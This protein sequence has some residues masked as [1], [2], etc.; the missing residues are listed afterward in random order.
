MKAAA[1]TSAP[2]VADRIAQ[3]L[4][5]YGVTQMFSQSLP[6][7]LILA[8]EDANIRQV[9]YRTENAGGA[10]A[11]AFARLSNKVGIV[12]AQNGPAATL[13]VP[14]L[15]EALKASIPI[16]ALVQEVPRHQSDK[17]AFQELDHHSLFIPCT[18]WVRTVRN[19]DRVEDYVRQAFLAATTGRPGPAALLLPADLLSEQTTQDRAI[20][21][22]FA[23]GR[24]PLDRTVANSDA[25]ARAADIIAQAESPIV[26]AGGGVHSAQGAAALAKLQEQMSLPVATTMMGK[27]SVDEGHPLSIGLVGNVMGRGS[28]GAHTRSI[29]D[30]ADV[31]LL[32][33][34]RTNQNGTDSWQLFPEN[35]TIIHVDIDGQEVGRNFPSVRLVGDVKLTLEGLLAALL[36][37]DL[38]KRRTKRPR[39]EE[40][41]ERARSTR[42]KISHEFMAS[43][44]SPLRP[45]R[46][47]A[48]LDPL[49]TPETVLVGDASYSSV[50][51]N[52]YLTAKAPGM[53]FLTPRGLAG[54]GWG[55]PMAI[56]AK[57]SDPK[58]P[59]ICLT[60]DGGFGH[61]WSELETVV[62]EGI[63]V[64]LIVLNNG[65]LGY[66]KDAEH[67]K[68]GR[69]TKACYFGPVNHAAIAEA[70][71]CPSRSIATVKELQ[72][73]LS[74]A[75]ESES[76]VLLDISTDPYAYPP[77]TM[78]DGALEAARKSYATSSKD[79]AQDG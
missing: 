61:C 72:S 56:G 25:I 24:W 2:V 75:L 44:A 35:A 66:Q 55:F 27:G 14:P 10:M 43:D 36:H 60:G 64:K 39:L 22:G 41:I 54:L 65:A 15:A 7:R 57:L 33:G 67:V 20:D 62:R 71:G 53:R 8:C 77:L 69:H 51:I 49:L 40:E 31:V 5:A 45:E 12:C 42:L 50:W 70:C 26:V 32:L 59:V 63:A 23:L 9:V 78:Y 13:L 3:Q 74:W 46:I 76:P 37:Q 58:R 38:T 48:E 79:T 68:F 1:V 19:A 21:D 52:A 30:D 11:D 18:K 4:K 73:A 28:L 34:T 16:V 6:S 29:I 17:N 47:M